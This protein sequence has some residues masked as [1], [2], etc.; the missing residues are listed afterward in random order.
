MKQIL[1]WVKDKKYLNYCSFHEDIIG[2]AKKR[3]SILKAQFCVI[4]VEM[5]V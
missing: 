1:S 4:I 2:E 5:Y 3:F